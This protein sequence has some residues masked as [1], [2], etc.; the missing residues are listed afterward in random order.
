MRVAPWPTLFVMLGIAEQKVALYLAASEGRPASASLFKTTYNLYSG[1][2]VAG[3]SIATFL[4]QS[5]WVN[6]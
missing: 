2:R 1:G 3:G 4:D 6:R 5:D